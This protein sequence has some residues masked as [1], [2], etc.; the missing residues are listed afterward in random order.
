MIDN[1]HKNEH[2]EKKEP[3]SHCSKIYGCETRYDNLFSAIK[4]NFFLAVSNLGKRTV[5]E[6]C[7]VIVL[8]IQRHDVLKVFINFRTIFVDVSPL[9]MNYDSNMDRK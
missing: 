9:L 1:L 7:S 5:E 6:I 4:K 3:Y 8:K 2:T